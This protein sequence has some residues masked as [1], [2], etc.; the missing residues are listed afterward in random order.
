MANI[1]KIAKLA[2]V[3]V[4][5]VS[6]ALNG[7]EDIKAETRNRILQIAKEMD[8]VPNVMARGLITKTTNTI[9]VFFG[10]QIN[11]G[12][13][14]PFLSDFFRAIKDTV[15][16]AGYDLLIFSNQKRDTSSY[17]TICTEKGVDGVI[18]ILT[19]KKRTD[20]KIHE[21]HEN[22]PTVYIDSLPNEKL[23]VN[24]V[25]SDNEGGAFQAVEHLIE[26]GHRRILKIAGDRIAR[27]SFSRIEGYKKALEKH[28]IAVDNSLIRYG[29]YSR[30]EAYKLTI[31]FFTD[32]TDVTAVFASSDLMA[33]GV[34]DALHDLGYRVPED[35]SVV[36]FDDI[37]SAKYHKPALTTVHQQRLK[38]GE[39]AAKIL[40]ELIRD[41]DNDGIT[42]HICIPTQLIIRESTAAKAK[43]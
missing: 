40:L 32:K 43:V 31:Q 12:F 30:D 8:Y 36:G 3:S 19:G 27:G 2:G 34:I 18:L 17:K 10:D 9:G 14:S 37:D 6:K 35:I 28:G 42:R 21:L 4:S 41:K 7:Y 23:R 24:F 38:M 20:E 11:S 5:T 29:L 39:T 16:E 26:L 25:E 33:Y 13:D 15:G 1:K 22:F